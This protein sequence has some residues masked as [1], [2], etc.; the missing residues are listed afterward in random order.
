MESYLTNALSPRLIELLKLKDEVFRQFDAFMVQLT[1]AMSPLNDFLR[2][3]DRERSISDLMMRAGWLPHNTTPFDQ[4]NSEFTIQTTGNV[5]HEYYSN[6]WPTVEE[7]LS[8]SISGYSIDNEARTTFMEGL[9]AHRNGLYRVA[10]RLL[11]PEIERI[12]RLELN[13]GKVTTIT[14][15]RELREETGQL[16]LSEFPVQGIYGMKIYNKSIEHL[17]EPAKTSQQIETARNDAVPNR[18]ATLHGLVSYT[19]MQSSLN[20]LI[21]TD[22]IFAAIDAIRDRRE[23]EALQT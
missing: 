17:Y 12:V 5:L 6:N 1:G 21:M 4:L 9:A 16:G 22:F 8:V 3:L 10:A 23:K 2:E 15:Q 18:H 13:L 14:S 7:A 11:F 20:M 19:T